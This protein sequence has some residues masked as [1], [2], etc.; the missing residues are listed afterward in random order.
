[1][2]KFPEVLKGED[3]AREAISRSAF[4]EF[5]DCPVTVR[6]AMRQAELDGR[7]VNQAARRCAK[8]ML[9]RIKD[10]LVR[11][12]V[13]ELATATNVEKSLSAFETYRD[14]L[15]RKIAN[16]FEEAAKSDSVA[17]YRLKRTKRIAIAGR[18]IMQPVSDKYRSH[19]S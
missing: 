5:A 10:P 11:R 12:Y 9:K 16:E 14:R 2:I 19:H 4:W 17:E 18:P 13:E 15:I 6:L 1:M 7:R 8:A 3:K